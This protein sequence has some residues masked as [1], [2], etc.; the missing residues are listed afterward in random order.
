MWEKAKTQ[1][2]LC[3][4]FEHMRENNGHWPYYNFQCIP[5]NENARN[6]MGIR[7]HQY[8]KT[9]QN[10]RCIEIICWSIHCICSDQRFY[11][12]APYIRE[13]WIF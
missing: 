2:V 8:N 12:P 5:L 3:V 1:I 11:L 7:F 9:I 4:S 6:E 13:A 10:D